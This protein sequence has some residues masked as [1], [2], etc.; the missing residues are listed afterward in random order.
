MGE[1]KG[2]ESSDFEVFFSHDVRFHASLNSK[3]LRVLQASLRRP[4]N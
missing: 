3:S 1:G 2:E 4:F